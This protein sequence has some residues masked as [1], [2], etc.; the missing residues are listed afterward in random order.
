MMSSLLSL[1]LT[2]LLFFSDC[3]YSDWRNE[4]A[5]S[6]FLMLWLLRR[7][8]CWF[9]LKKKI[10]G[11]ENVN[12]Q[13]SD[14]LHDELD[15][16]TMVSCW[17]ILILNKRQ[18]HWF[19]SVKYWYWNLEKR[20]TLIIRNSFDH[21]KLGHVQ[22]IFRSPTVLKNLFSDMPIT[23]QKYFLVQF[24]RKQDSK[25]RRVSRC[26]CTKLMAWESSLGNL[27]FW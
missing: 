18:L 13:P 25:K 9:D 10:C 27:K 12:P 5:C 26:T 23:C 1:S 17:V 24:V 15:H 22:Y 14:L 6:L 8:F 11:S 3:Y 16:R 21:A 2:C 4:W 19:Y 20:L 7:D